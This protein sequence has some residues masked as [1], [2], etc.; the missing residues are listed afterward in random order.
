MADLE[1][2]T[3]PGGEP[4]PAAVMAG[5]LLGSWSATRWQYTR[6]GEPAQVI[7]L[8]CDLHGNLTLSLSQGNF[9]LTWQV[10]GI[11]GQ[12]IGGGCTVVSDQLEFVVPWSGWSEAVAFHLGAGEL[13]LRS[14]NSA[15]DF[16]G[17]GHEEPAGFVAVFVKL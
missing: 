14:D 1:V 13:S 9:I 16:E 15:W 7:D 2:V 5:G 8:V 12:S 4:R 3:G 10:P 17:R 6:Q 11:R